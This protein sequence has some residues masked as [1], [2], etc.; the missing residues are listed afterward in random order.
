MLTALLYGS[1]SC[2]L[3][4]LLTIH[5]KDQIKWFHHKKK[6]RCWASRP[7]NVSRM[8]NCPLPDHYNK[9]ALRK[10]KVTLMK[11]F[12][13]SDI[14]L[15]LKTLEDYNQQCWHIAIYQATSNFEATIP[16]WGKTGLCEK[17]CP[18]RYPYKPDILLQPMQKV[19]PSYIWLSSHQ[20]VYSK[21]EKLTKP[22]NSSSILKQLSTFWKLMF[23]SSDLHLTKVTLRTNSKTK[24]YLDHNTRTFESVLLWRTTLFLSAITKLVLCL[25]LK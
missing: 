23:T 17:T 2:Y 6:L 5:P 25:I 8:K 16:A 13:L 1:E 11:D 14:S 9:S 24:K 19:W 4:V 12:P 10:C 7:E 20:Q 21:E 15:H 22:S 18:R 3:W